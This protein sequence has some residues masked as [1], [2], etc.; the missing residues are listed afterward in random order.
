MGGGMGG[1]ADMDLL[2]WNLSRAGSGHLMLGTG[3]GQP[4]TGYRYA[5][6]TECA[7]RLDAD[8]D[9][10][11][12]FIGPWKWHRGSGSLWMCDGWKALHE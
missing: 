8:T 11:N 3:D 12:L 10:W 6:R 2:P 9:I 4:R 1:A 7:H 5:G